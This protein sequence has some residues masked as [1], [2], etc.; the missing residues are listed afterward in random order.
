MTRRIVN[1]KGNQ[2]GMRVNSERKGLP[3]ALE[4]EIMY[5][6]FMRFYLQGM[7]DLQIAEA[8]GCADKTVNRWRH[9]NNLTNIYNKFNEKQKEAE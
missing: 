7:S 5:A 4:R 6:Q 1:P 8:A 3:D 9:R 2:F